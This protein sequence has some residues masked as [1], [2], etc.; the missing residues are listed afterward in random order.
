MFE[1]CL[2]E[3][4]QSGGFRPLFTVLWYTL[5]LDFCDAQPFEVGSQI[6]FAHDLKTRL[7]KVGPVKMVVTWMGDEG[8]SADKRA[9]IGEL[10]RELVGYQM[11]R[12]KG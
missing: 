7:R 8:L 4:I 2:K 12:G 5:Y 6:P 10:M 1:I 3:L 11:M 9:Q